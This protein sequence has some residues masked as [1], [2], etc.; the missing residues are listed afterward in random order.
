[1]TQAKR[2]QPS[3]TPAKEEQPEQPE[4]LSQEELEAGLR[5]ERHS[6]AHDVSP[7]AGDE[8]MEGSDARKAKLKEAE[9]GRDEQK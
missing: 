7:Q 3:R 6:L 4:P 2:S 8:L 9:A 5:A 1:M